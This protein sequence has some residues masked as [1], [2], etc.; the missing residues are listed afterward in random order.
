[1]KSLKQTIAT[2]TN[3]G[4]FVLGVIAVISAFKPVM[5]IYITLPLALLY[6][7]AQLV[8]TVGSGMFHATFDSYWRHWDE[9]GM[10]AVFNVHLAILFWQVTGSVWVPVVMAIILSVYMGY[11]FYDLSSFVILPIMVLLIFFL[12]WSSGMSL[13]FMLIFLGALVLAGTGWLLEEESKEEE[14]LG[15]EKKAKRYWLYADILH[16]AWHPATQVAMYFL[17]LT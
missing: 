14:R 5:G 4:Y 1:M 3:L 13:W 10:Y 6:L 12:R 16:G 7:G 2:I 8:L 11:L 15:N 17:L 9:R